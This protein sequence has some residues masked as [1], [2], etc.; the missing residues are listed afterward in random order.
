MP[1]LSRIYNVDE[2]IRGAAK[3]GHCRPTIADHFNSAQDYTY[4][5]CSVQPVYDTNME[6]I[7]DNE[8]ETVTVPGVEV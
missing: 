5:W 7:Y 4:A 8:G 6:L 2:N 3:D 1:S